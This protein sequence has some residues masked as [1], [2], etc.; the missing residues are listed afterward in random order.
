MASFQC[1]KCGHDQ[2]RTGELRASGGFWTKFFNIQNETY[3]TLICTNCGYTELYNEET[4]TAENV[5]DFF[6][7]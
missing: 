4:S 3:Q 1:E 2:Y 7:N 5:L 6:G